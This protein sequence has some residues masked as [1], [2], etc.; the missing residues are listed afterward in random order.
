ME[1]IMADLGSMP[2]GQLAGSIALLAAALSTV[3]EI[4]PIKLNPWSWLARKIGKA[5]NGEVLDKVDQLEKRVDSLR[6]TV[7]E[8]SAVDARTRILRFGD[9]C[10]H[11]DRHSK[12]HFDQ[13]LR[14]ITAYELYCNDHPNFK[15]NTAVLTIGSIKAIY[16]Q[17]LRDHDF[18]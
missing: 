13:I 2:A 4:S 8:R 9:E 3:I 18:L 14:D 5:I 16:K 6:D 17:R 1:P 7:E 10:L 12:E 11:G 15:N